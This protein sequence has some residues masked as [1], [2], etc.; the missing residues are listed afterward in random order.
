MQITCSFR[1]ELQPDKD[2]RSLMSR[3]AGCCR[4]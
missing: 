4:L 1:F 2:Q 3:T